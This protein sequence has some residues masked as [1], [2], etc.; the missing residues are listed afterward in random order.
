MKRKIEKQ[1]E[2]EN[3]TVSELTIAISSDGNNAVT[4]WPDDEYYHELEYVYQIGKE[5]EISV[6][7]DLV[8]YSYDNKTWKT[9]IGTEL[10][11]DP[12]QTI[13]LKCE[14]SNGKPFYYVASDA[15]KPVIL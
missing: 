4:V 5:E 8:S 14:A 12:G 7:L 10:I 11:L 15:K 9:F 3:Q 13:Y 1:L 2:L 6:S